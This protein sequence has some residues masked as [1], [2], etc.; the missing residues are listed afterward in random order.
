MSL[1]LFPRELM[2]SYF[3]MMENHHFVCVCVVSS[4]Y[5]QLFCHLVG[6]KSIHIQFS[7][8][9]GFNHFRTCGPSNAIKKYGPYFLG[10]W[11]P[12]LSLNDSLMIRPY[13]RG[14]G[15]MGGMPLWFVFSILPKSW[16]WFGHQAHSIG[17]IFHMVIFPKD[18]DEIDEFEEW[19]SQEFINWGDW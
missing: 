2:M 11:S 19:S 12:S 13:F 3:V 10:L 9:T 7:K 15:G 14:G 1:L 5:S 6:V 16:L 17:S 18:L 4:W 8:G